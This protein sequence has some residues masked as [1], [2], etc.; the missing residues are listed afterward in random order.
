MSGTTAAAVTG[1]SI[2]G[3]TDGNGDGQQQLGNPEFTEDRPEPGG[4]TMA[5]LPTSRAR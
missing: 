2:A 3:C 5:E 4:T 1:A